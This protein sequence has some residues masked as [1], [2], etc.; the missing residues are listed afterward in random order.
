M[1]TF[2]HLWGRKN[3]YYEFLLEY[4]VI[5]KITLYGNLEIRDQIVKYEGYFIFPLSNLPFLDV[6]EHA[7]WYVLWL[8]VFISTT[9]FYP[10]IKLF[11]NTLP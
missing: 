5:K 6:C 11:I 7:D 1:K 3:Y 10:I 4:N 9:K 8:I 2:S